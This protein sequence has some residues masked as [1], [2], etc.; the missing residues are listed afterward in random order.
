[1]TLRLGITVFLAAFAVDLMT[2]AWA[3]GHASVVYD[4]APGELP[5]R[6]VMSVIAVGV[7]VI[8]ARIARRRGLG[9]QWGV[10]VGCAL[11]VA[12]ILGNGVSSLV[13]SQGVPDFIVM[14]DGWVWNL[15]DFEIGVGLTGGIASVAV[16]AV[17][18]YARE[19]LSRTTPTH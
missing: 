17:A 19:R 5:R 3:I 12:G 4:T 1:M 9:R 6:I 8:L 15:A 10:T 11:L 13:W 14:R 18:V 2:K 7:A 16:V